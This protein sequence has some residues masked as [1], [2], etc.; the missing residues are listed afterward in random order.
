[1]RLIDECTVIDAFMHARDYVSDG[2]GD[3]IHVYEEIWQSKDT[4]HYSLGVVP[5]LIDE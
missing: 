2:T 1:M 5:V 4:R 3:D